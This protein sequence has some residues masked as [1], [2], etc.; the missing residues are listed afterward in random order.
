MVERRS[1][2]ASRKRLTTPEERQERVK[3]QERRAD[4]K[5]PVATR[6]RR[7]PSV[8]ALEQTPSPRL[9]SVSVL[10]VSEDAMRNDATQ[11]PAADVAQTPSTSTPR[12]PDVR[13]SVR[14]NFGEL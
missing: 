6:A 10:P 1:P 14:Q 13:Q 12:N 4:A 7:S 9:V 2:M 3:R 5:E 11:R 8:D